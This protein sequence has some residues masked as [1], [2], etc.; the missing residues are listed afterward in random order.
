SILS[1]RLEDLSDPMVPIFTHEYAVD[2]RRFIGGDT[3]YVG[4]G[5]GTGGLTA[6]AGIQKWQV[7]PAR[8]PG[9]V[10]PA[11]PGDLRVTT[12]GADTVDL[13][14]TCSSTN[15]TGFI[16]ERAPTAGGPFHE[17]ART[18]APRYTD[19]GLAPGFYFYQV[20]AYNDQGT[21]AASNTALAS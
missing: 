6:L 16:I 19:S 8:V 5:G 12:I 3:A 14:W 1:E 13:A 17:V 20:R 9:D 10:P 21:S 2:L 7:T 15:E 11:G 18:M 4:F